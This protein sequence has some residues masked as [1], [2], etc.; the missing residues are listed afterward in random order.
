MI[1]PIL[2]HFFHTACLMHRLLRNMTK[3]AKSAFSKNLSHTEGSSRCCSQIIMKLHVL[4]LDTGHW[5]TRCPQEPGDNCPVAW[6]CSFVCFCFLSIVF[7]FT[8]VQRSS[9]CSFFRKSSYVSQMSRWVWLVCINATPLYFLF[10]IFL[11]FVFEITPGIR[12]SVLFSV[13]WFG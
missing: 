1:I 10:F 9:W 4:D 6:V 2:Q 5:R 11:L 8:E 12:Y 7:C 3:R 13:L